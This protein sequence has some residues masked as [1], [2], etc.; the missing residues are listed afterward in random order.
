MKLGKYSFGI[1]DRFAHQGKAQL[2]AIMLAKEQ[3]INITPV[4][5]KSFREHDIVGSKPADVRAE[6]AA[7]VKALNWRDAYFVDA[8]HIGMKNVD[9]F[10]ESSDFF[11]IDVADFIGKPADEKKVNLFIEQQKKYI[12]QISI[13][14]IPQKIEISKNQIE[15][16]ARKYL[17]AI[18]EASKIYA[19]IFTQ[20]GSN[21]FVVEVSMDETNAPQTPIEL[22][23]ILAGLAQKEILLA[24][25]AP[26][27]SG[28]FNKGVDYV[29]D[30][31][32]F[33]IEFEQ[34]VAV[35]EYA[36]REF[37]LP[38]ELKLSVHSGSDKFSIYPSIGQ[39]LKKFDAG[40]HIKTAGT[41]WLE[42][43]IGLAEAGEKGLQI[44]KDIYRN[45]YHRFE[46]LSKPYATVIDIDPEQLPTP[47][48]VYLWD[49]PT[50]VETLRHEKANPHYNLNFRQLLHVGYKVA[51][52]MK[53]R[54][55][56]ALK[57]YEA[58]IAKNVTQNIFDRHIKPIFL[59]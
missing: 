7:A 30:V 39:A 49:G 26:K 28:R 24:T 27:F 25:L 48:Q 51:A 40:V 38:D 8:D 50:Y 2:S 14:G 11:T 35:I 23:F 15:A 32:R 59:T 16:I 3:G 41:T 21:P 44:A 19:H 45:A 17:F 37:R 10:L 33:T 34:D 47:D 1:G 6:A 29:G 56:D 12:G 20:K 53:D 9:F 55:L 52:E 42:E 54:Y 4:W 13:P 22:L 5:N 18:E 58:V 31:D 57:K 43:I 46:E 36:K